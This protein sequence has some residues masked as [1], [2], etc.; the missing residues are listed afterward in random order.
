[1]ID[2]FNFSQQAQKLLRFHIDKKTLNYFF[3]SKSNKSICLYLILLELSN[4]NGKCFIKTKEIIDYFNFKS[5]KTIC[6][7]LKDL[8]NDQLINATYNIE[9][10][11]WE[12]KILSERHIQLWNNE[13][14]KNIS[15]ENVDSYLY[16]FEKEQE[17]LDCIKDNQITAQEE[18]T[19]SNASSIPLVLDDSSSTKEDTPKESQS[20]TPQVV[21]NTADETMDSTDSTTN[22]LQGDSMSEVIINDEIT[23]QMKDDSERLANIMTNSPLGNLMRQIFRDKQPQERKTKILI[24]TPYKTSLIQD[25]D[26][27][28]TLRIIDGYEEFANFFITS[29]GASVISPIREAINKTKKEY[30]YLLSQNENKK[31]YRK[32]QENLNQINFL[33]ENL[34]SSVDE[35]SISTIN[36]NNMREASKIEALA[37][38]HNKIVHYNLIPSFCDFDESEQILNDSLINDNKFN[39]EHFFINEYKENPLNDK[40]KLDNI[41]HKNFTYN[42]RNYTIDEY[43]L[44]DENQIQINTTDVNLDPKTITLDVNKL[45]SS[46]V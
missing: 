31:Y 10:H 42:G 12:I 19:T 34:I 46:L 13:K 36:Y 45:L 24:Y 11:F 6:N 43:F 41:L 38:K 23:K 9:K 22:H 1:M 32:L 8:N 18:N 37:K 15:S 2:L 4:N 21:T 44:L 40:N 39:F 5:T 30:G 17:Q 28:N 7:Y 26:Y 14:I 27:E 29:S 3:A 16:D 20:Q 35:I 33:S 25:I